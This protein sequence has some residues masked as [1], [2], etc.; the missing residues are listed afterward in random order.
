[1]ILGLLGI[2]FLAML[3][4]IKGSSWPNYPGPGGD[5]EFPYT[6]NDT[7]KRIAWALGLTLVNLPVVFSQWGCHII[8]AFA[9]PFLA[10]GAATL[11]HAQF[12]SMGRSPGTTFITCF[13]GMAAVGLATGAILFAPACYF[14]PAWAIA[15]KISMLTVG[16][17]IA[18]TM[19]YLMNFSVPDLLL[20]KGDTSW[21]EF[22]TGAAYFLSVLA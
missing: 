3:Y 13:F 10:F 7:E 15:L 1:M 21:G 14:M 8:Y 5:F 17:P 19:G 12:Q 11:P 6:W 4:R 18:Y 9:F 22:Y 2:F 20:K 16:M